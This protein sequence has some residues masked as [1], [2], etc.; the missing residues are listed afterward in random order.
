MKLLNKVSMEEALHYE[1]NALGAFSYFLYVTFLSK[2]YKKMWVR[3][4]NRYLSE[5]IADAN[6][7]DEIEEA[8]KQGAALWERHRI[9]LE[10]ELDRRRND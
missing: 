10:A 7:E 2:W 3:K 9:K 5:I 6:A 4:Y 8:R 1:E